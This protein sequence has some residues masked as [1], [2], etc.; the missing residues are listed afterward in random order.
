MRA[1]GCRCSSFGS[2]WTATAEVAAFV[3]FRPLPAD[4][5]RRARLDD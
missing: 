2:L 1:Q 3:A 4:V 5:L